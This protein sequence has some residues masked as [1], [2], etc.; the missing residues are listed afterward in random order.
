MFELAQFLVLTAGGSAAV[1]V[2]EAR[3]RRRALTRS[4]V[5]YLKASLADAGS[6]SG[7]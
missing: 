4:W 3:R 5:D 7:P 6:G 1:L 2:A